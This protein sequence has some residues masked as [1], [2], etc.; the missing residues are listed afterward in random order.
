MAIR[1]RASLRHHSDFE[2]SSQ[3]KA[4]A[5]SNHASTCRLGAASDEGAAEAPIFPGSGQVFTVAVA[6]V[7]CRARA[8]TAVNIA[9]VSLLVNV[10]CWLVVRAI[11]IDRR[12]RPRRGGQRKRGRNHLQRCQDPADGVHPNW[13]RATTRAVSR[14]PSSQKGAH[15][16]RPR[17]SLVRRQQRTRAIR[18]R[19]A[20]AHSALAD[21]GRQLNIVIHRKSLRCHRQRTSYLVAIMAGASPTTIRVRSRFE[22]RPAR[23]SRKRATFAAT[24]RASHQANIGSR[25]SSPSARRA[26]RGSIAGVAIGHCGGRDPAARVIHIIPLIADRRC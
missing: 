15:A 7:M 10:F 4:P 18:R 1:Y 19:G 24:S 3:S 26:A 22:P 12:S 17:S 25:R 9:A 6:A 8:S 11:S 16:S 21:A 23:P 2:R 14:I 5:R 13:L 20:P